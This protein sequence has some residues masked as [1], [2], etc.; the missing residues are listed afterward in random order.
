VREDFYP[1]LL[2][3]GKLTF[4]II[5]KIKWTFSQNIMMTYRVNRPSPRLLCCVATSKSSTYVNL[6]PNQWTWI[7]MNGVC[8][9]SFSINRWVSLLS[10]A[11]TSLA[12]IP[13]HKNKDQWSPI[14]QSHRAS[15][16]TSQYWMGWLLLL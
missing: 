3:E 13:R 9:P 5:G 10:W 7:L 14:H 15:D 8:L 6:N 4:T 2:R 1:V 16:L 12:S 11:S